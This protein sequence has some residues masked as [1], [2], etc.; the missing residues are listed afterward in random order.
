MDLPVGLV[1]L[2][3]HLPVILAPSLA[4]Y[5]LLRHGAFLFYP[6]F[7]PPHVVAILTSLIATPIFFLLS[8]LWSTLTN[9]RSAAA[10]GTVIAPYVQSDFLGLSNVRKIVQSFKD[11]YPGDVFLDWIKDYGNTYSLKMLAEHRMVTIEPDHIKAILA[12]QFDDF[13]KG[14]ILFSQLSSLLGTG[15]FNSDAERWKFHRSMTRPFFS[16]ERIAHFDIFDRH[17]TDALNQ[18]QARLNE[19]YPIDFQDMVSRFT[20]DS[21]TEFLFGK[22]VKSLSAG[23]PY[24]S[25]SPLA[26]STLSNHPANI[27][28]EAF[29]EGQYL[30]ALR[31]RYGPHWPLFEWTDRIKPYRDIVN[32]FIDPI[33]EDALLKAHNAGDAGDVETDAKSLSED[34]TLLSHLIKMTQGSNLC[35]LNLQPYLQRNDRSPDH[36]G[37]DFKHYDRWSGHGRILVHSEALR[38]IRPLDSNHADLFSLHAISASKSPRQATSGGFGEGRIVEASNV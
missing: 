37:R 5:V 23:L 25:S 6:S 11:G 4:T 29:M 12:T 7:D 33:I 16:K 1:H 9:S 18:A 20:L 17:A 3:I 26:A 34:E 32:R 2:I 15:V 21:A 8:S 14:P 13:A 28:A 36:P 35:P 31:T 38:L 24:P 10:R 19:G 30:T 22:D 27:F